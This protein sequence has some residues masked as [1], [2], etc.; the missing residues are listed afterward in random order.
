MGDWVGNQPRSVLLPS[1]TLSI[2]WLLAIHHAEDEVRMKGSVLQLL[3]QT[4]DVDVDLL[5]GPSHYLTK[6][7][8][9]TTSKVLVH[10]DIEVQTNFVQLLVFGPWGERNL[11]VSRS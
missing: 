1:H 8:L 9:K 2:Q 11:Q 7:K 4:F 3:L 6:H 5:R 10:S